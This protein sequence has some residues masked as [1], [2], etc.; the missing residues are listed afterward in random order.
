VHVHLQIAALVATLAA[1]APLRAGPGAIRLTL[2]PGVGVLAPPEDEQTWGLMGGAS[3][4][5]GIT[6]QLWIQAHGDRKVFPGHEPALAATAVGATLTYNLDLLYVSP[7]I[8]AGGG[9]VRISRR[10]GIG[11]S[12]DNL[13]PI[14]G[15]GLEF[16][17]WEWLLAGLGVRYYP[18][19][20]TDLLE[21][22]A[23]ATIHGRV[24]V[25][26]SPWP[27]E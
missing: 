27:G 7:Y 5:V 16:T 11:A 13:V 20:E 6:D 25:I 19:F 4:A 22:P 8:E 3:L 1:A 26:F 12:S 15:F 9:W 18:V 21:S 14:L 24:G 23:Y 2:E 10:D 17:W